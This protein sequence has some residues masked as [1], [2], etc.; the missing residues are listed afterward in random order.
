MNSFLQNILY[1]LYF[2]FGILYFAANYAIISCSIN[3]LD[4]FISGA[5]INVNIIL[6]YYEEKSKLP[7]IYRERIP[8]L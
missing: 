2:L 8:M 6:K 7:H 4:F 5:I 3:D 1:F